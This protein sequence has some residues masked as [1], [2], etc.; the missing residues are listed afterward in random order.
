MTQRNPDMESSQAILIIDDSPIIIRL[1]MSLVEGQATVYFAKSGEDGIKMA[2]KI[3]PAV[4]LLDLEMPG[5]NGLEV[6]R[7]LK[8]DPDTRDSSILIVTGH[9]TEATEIAALDAGAVDFITKPVNSPIVQAR[10]RTHLTLQQQ[11]ATLRQLAHQDGLTGLFNRRAFDAA[12]QAEYRR[13]RRQNLALGLAFIDI[14][15]FKHYNDH[16]G[17]V[18]GDDTLKSV[19]S[20]LQDAARRPG[21]VAARYGGEEFALIVPSATPHDMQ[22]F[23][24]RLCERIRQLGIA[25]A[26]SATANV[27]TISVG[28][29]SCIPSQ[30]C[31]AN[32]MLVA[33]DAALYKA[34]SGGRNR[35][36]LA[37]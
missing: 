2:K 15:H 14:D 22:E 6:C 17:H 26:Q 16:Y 33:A 8:A 23:G 11:S 10:V 7:A 31:D 1:L 25:H 35:A 36:M 27:V 30:D 21:E 18:L 37:D 5:M 19:A 20:A 24:D 9:D 12:L 34:K 28:L 29:M 4:I 13:H 32:S 3:Q